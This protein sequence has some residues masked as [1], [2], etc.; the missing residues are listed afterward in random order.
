M[1]KNYSKFCWQIQGFHTWYLPL[2]RMISYSTLISSRIKALAWGLRNFWVIWKNGPVLLRCRSWEGLEPLLV[3]G[4]FG[5]WGRLVCKC[6]NFWGSWKIGDESKK[7]E[8]NFWRPNK[9][10]IGAELQGKELREGKYLSVIEFH[11]IMNLICWNL[12]VKHLT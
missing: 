5:Q 6:R 10:E 2:R 7:L 1:Q 12:G 11:E 9:M 4:F 3:S 8:E